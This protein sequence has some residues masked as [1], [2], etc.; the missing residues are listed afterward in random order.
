[1]PVLINNGGLDR[2]PA[3]FPYICS[4]FFPGVNDP[5]VALPPASLGTKRS[6][7]LRSQTASGCM[8]LSSAAVAVP[9][10]SISAARRLQ[11]ALKNRDRGCG[12]MPTDFYKPEYVMK[13]FARRKINP[14][15][16]NTFELKRGNSKIAAEGGLQTT[17]LQCVTVSYFLLLT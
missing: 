1:M 11:S 9:G 10:L 5:L 16:N 12:G 13:V 2:M 14:E 4:D 17:I 3:P 15:R 7:F 8:Q 6:L